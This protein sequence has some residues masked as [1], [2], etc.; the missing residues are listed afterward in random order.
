VYPLTK[1]ALALVARIIRAEDRAK[2]L[3]LFEARA[4]AGRS[5]QIGANHVLEVVL[6]TRYYTRLGEGLQG[7]PGSGMKDVPR[8]VEAEWGAVLTAPEPDDSWIP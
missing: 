4:R 3:E 2:Y 8:D 5:A 6:A 1:T 7:G